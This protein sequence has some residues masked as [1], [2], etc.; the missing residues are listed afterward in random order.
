MSILFRFEF[1]AFV[2]VENGRSYIMV[3]M[4]EVSIN[5]FGF[6]LSF[7]CGGNLTVMSISMIVIVLRFLFI[8]YYFVLFVYIFLFAFASFCIKSTNGNFIRR[9]QA[10]RLQ[11]DVTAP[12]F[13]VR[14]ENVT[15]ETIDRM[16]RFIEQSMWMW[17]TYRRETEIKCKHKTRFVFI[18][19]H[20]K[21]YSGL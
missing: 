2:C 21:N 13:E 18:L 19:Y 15:R 3:N 17:M 7:C 4:W 6:F 20:R 14:I 1:I 11:S 9:W 10:H 16:M 5:L 12:Y 8:Y